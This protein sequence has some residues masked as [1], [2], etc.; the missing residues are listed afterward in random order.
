ML[1]VEISIEESFQALVIKKLFLFMKLSIPSF[2]CVDPLAWWCIHETQFLNVGFLVKKILEISSSQ[3][4]IERLFNFVG[5][6]TTLK[7]FFL[8]VKNMDHIIFVVKN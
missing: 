2:A 4:E 8:Q 1:G 3:I 5:V 7:H 6:L